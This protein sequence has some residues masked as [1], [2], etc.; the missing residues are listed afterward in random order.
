[1]SPE[2]LQIYNK[3]GT[4]DFNPEKCDV[5]STGLT[6]LRLALELS[7]IDIAEMNNIDKGQQLIAIQLNRLSTFWKTLLAEMLQ[8]STAA[9]AGAVQL[10]WFG[11]HLQQV[12]ALV[13]HHCRLR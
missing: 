13:L 3:S 9:R 6:Y 8:I 5:F 11:F 7:E 4:G 12:S 10:V 2:M 1:M